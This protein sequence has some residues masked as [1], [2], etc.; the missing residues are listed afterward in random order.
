MGKNIKKG[1]SLFLAI[2]FVCQSSGYAGS[3]S[4]QFT[5]HHTLAAES[6]LIEIKRGM[7]ERVESED[8]VIARY[9]AAW[10]EAIAKGM[11]EGE[12]KTSAAKEIETIVKGLAQHTKD[13]W[14]NERRDMSQTEVLKSIK[15]VLN[16][17]GAWLEKEV[18]KQNPG[19]VV[20]IIQQAASLARCISETKDPTVEEIKVILGVMGDWLDK[21]AMT[22][23]AEINPAAVAEIMKQVIS[24][25]D[26]GKFRKITVKEMNVILQNVG[27]WLGK[28]IVISNSLQAIKIM[29]CAADLASLAGIQGY[30]DNVGGIL[31]GLQGASLW[32]DK[33]VIINNPEQAAAVMEQAVLIATL[34]RRVKGCTNDEIKAGLDVAGML[35][36]NGFIKNNPNKAAE[37]LTQMRH[38]VSDI[39]KTKNGTVADVKDVLDIMRSW[40]D[41]PAMMRLAETNP[42]SIVETIKQVVYLT[43]YVKG[44]K[45]TVEELKSVL[46]LGLKILSSDVILEK[47][48]I[49]NV[50]EMFYKYYYVFLTEAKQAGLHRLNFLCDRE[51]FLYMVCLAV[52]TGQ[53]I[54][55]EISGGFNE[56]KESIPAL[57]PIKASNIV[58]TPY[59]VNEIAKVEDCDSFCAGFS[60]KIDAVIEDI[61]EGDLD[62]LVGIE[63][64]KK[65]LLYNYLF[66][67]FPEVMRYMEYENYLTNPIVGLLVKYLKNPAYVNKVYGLTEFL[68]L[69]DRIKSTTEQEGLGAAKSILQKRGLGNFIDEYGKIIRKISLREEAFSRNQAEVRNFISQLFESIKTPNGY[70][71]LPQFRTAIQM[72]LNEEDGYGTNVLLQ[73]RED[74]ISDPIVQIRVSII[75][76]EPMP[77][78][79]LLSERVR[80]VL[81]NHLREISIYTAER[82]TD[83]ASR[84]AIV[85]GIR[86]FLEGLLK[87]AG[88]ILS[89]HRM[90]P[91]KITGYSIEKLM[92]D[93]SVTEEERDVRKTEVLGVLKKM[94]YGIDEKGSVILAAMDVVTSVY[95]GTLEKDSTWAQFVTHSPEH[96]LCTYA[97]TGSELAKYGDDDKKA[98]GNKTLQEIDYALIC[99][100]RNVIDPRRVDDKVPLAFYY[101][102]KRSEDEDNLLK[103]CYKRIVVIEGKSGLEVFEDIM[104]KQKKE[105]VAEEVMLRILSAIEKGEISKEQLPQYFDIMREMIEILREVYNWEYWVSMFGYM[106]EAF[107]SELVNRYETVSD[108]HALLVTALSKARDRQLEYLE[109]MFSDSE[110]LQEHRNRLLVRQLRMQKDKWEADGK[111]ILDFLRFKKEIREQTYA[112]DENRPDITS[113]VDRIMEGVA[114][115][116][117]KTYREYAFESYKK[118]MTGKLVDD[119]E[120]QEVIS[121]VPKKSSAEELRRFRPRREWF[122]KIPSSMHG[123]A[124]E[125]RVLVLAETIMNMIGNVKLQ[126]R[127]AVRLSSVTHDV[128]RKNDG[129]DDGGIDGGHGERAAVWVGQN[130]RRYFPNAGVQKV[131]EINRG[132][133]PD[134]TEVMSGLLKIF[135]DA[136]ALDRWRLGGSPNLKMLRYEQSKQLAK[137]AKYLYEISS[138]LIT[139]FGVSDFEAVL[140]AGKI[141]G[142]IDGEVELPEE[143]L[144]RAQL[145]DDAGLPGARKTEHGQE[146][147]EHFTA[148]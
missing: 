129:S 87:H 32:L 48:Q 136:D 42:A 113:E 51:Q 130:L 67:Q 110:P 105:R 138:E 118:W 77:A 16:A 82:I 101:G 119:E 53:K 70:L 73:H 133:V 65:S 8:Q 104:D 9:I 1:I 11:G 31:A 100:E 62:N 29:K 115:E 15:D 79:A 103:Y 3:V 76:G 84:P 132:H 71:S 59:I 148:V 43:N 56:F 107:Y 96:A 86:I 72:V 147:Y 122:L 94:G 22:K 143:G 128:R 25:M 47:E 90:Y 74:L 38:L 131:A 137:L 92:S 28:N 61:S 54:E 13:T 114:V 5:Q 19:Q 88:Y 95:R 41:E 52:K 12:Q 24:S 45:Y 125:S 58:L 21:P 116:R 68:Q 124:H 135:K 89:G 69:L 39:K 91:D 111:N 57:R 50:V 117:I 33:E 139:R 144:Y 37:I 98:M 121:A 106:D 120:L 63:E 30:V 40:L 81:L 26:V 93:I 99:Y 6:F 141:M 14:N 23:I 36:D 140:L 134:D 108:R 83:Y 2:L 44:D 112:S 146:Q 80:A 97:E 102:E 34:V 126:D 78:E 66:R 75:Y 18:V 85:R 4:I 17:A 10:K 142:I 145:G 35:L 7:D 27:A 109:K 49:S 20:G 123:V 46:K 55:N 127:D 60:K 64:E